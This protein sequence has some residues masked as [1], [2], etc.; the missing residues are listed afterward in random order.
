MT[1]GPIFN[2]ELSII[3]EKSVEANHILN[4]DTICPIKE[5]STSLIIPDD[6][7]TVEIQSTT[8][9]FHEPN[10]TPEIERRKKIRSY[11][12]QSLLDGTI[13]Q[14]MFSKRFSQT[15]LIRRDSKS[16][17][18]S[19]ESEQFSALSTYQKEIFHDLDIKDGTPDQRISKKSFQKMLEHSSRPS[20][21]SLEISTVDNS[22]M[23]KRMISVADENND[24]FI[25]MDEYAGLMKK[26]ETQPDG[27]NKELMNHI[28]AIHHAPTCRVWPPPL[29][30]LL[31]SLLQISMFIYHVVHLSK[32]H[33]MSI[34]WT[35]P[36]P[37][38]SI[39]IYNHE[40]RKQVWRM[41]TYA[42]VH[43]GVGHVILNIGM[44]LVVGLPLEMTHGSTRVGGVYI[45]GVISGCLATA[46][47]TPHYH[48]AGAS[49]GVY[50]LL[51]ANLSNL[52]LN[53]KEE[54]LIT[55]TGHRG[56]GSATA[57][58][59]GLFKVVKLTSILTYIIVDTL[60][61]VYSLNYG[62]QNTTG[63][64]AHIAGAVM[65]LISGILILKNRRV[66][67][68]EVWMRLCCYLL[69]TI[70]LALG[71]LWQIVGDTVYEAWTRKPGQPGQT[72]FSPEVPGL[73]G[74]NQ[75]KFYNVT[76]GN[77]EE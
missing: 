41:L 16:S 1:K 57:M 23:F 48:L 30:L 7:E 64:V 40:K 61:A 34:F 71:V 54:D 27:H 8:P 31:V 3:S 35:G 68:Y 49:S 67:T 69:I 36:A 20:E 26:L 74:H 65:G 5:E 25:D 6:Q 11:S 56:Q 59:A 46:C 42:I 38:C 76:T 17:I 72:F 62:L 75:C 2:R 12:S 15:S 51:A 33:D 50:S 39:W 45:L 18:S 55:F 29:F 52:I 77:W 10:E 28:T 4:S 19:N 73:G 24:G 14:R 43:A 53:W 58:Q 13:L 60:L 32:E 70:L 47:F 21:W 37:Y 66:E 44:Q 9:E 63:Y 22:E